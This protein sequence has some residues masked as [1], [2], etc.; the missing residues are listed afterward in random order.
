MRN[1]LRFQ[2]RTALPPN[3]LRTVFGT[4]AR[5]DARSFREMVNVRWFAD[6]LRARFQ[7]HFHRPFSLRPIPEVGVHYR[8]P[9][10]SG[11]PLIMIV[12]PYCVY[13]PTHGGA[14]RIHELIHRL[15]EKFDIILLSD[16]SEHYSSAS[17]EYFQKCHLVC[18][19]RGR[20]AHPDF[21]RINR[22]LTHSNRT[23]A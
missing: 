18:L 14:R 21:G 3:A 1:R 8:R 17:L 12:S 20:K 19:V 6:T 5:L 10:R 11:C 15:A 23:L 7:F 22:I 2:L 16:E 4:I 13:P 9:R